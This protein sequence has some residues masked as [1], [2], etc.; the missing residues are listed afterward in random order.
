MRQT[1]LLCSVSWLLLVLAG[2]G[3]GQARLM[4]DLKQTG[5]AY[6]NYHDTHQQGPANW[7]ELIAFEK[8]SGGDGVGLTRVRDAGYEMKFGVRF[9]DVAEGLSNTV[10][11]EKPGGGPRLMMDGSVQ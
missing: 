9:P 7:D 2:C 11:A 6:H 10:L 3:G 5:L 1:A 4:N 8:A